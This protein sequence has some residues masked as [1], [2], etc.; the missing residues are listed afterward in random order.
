LGGELFT[1]LLGSRL[2]FG[3]VDLMLAEGVRCGLGEAGED[4]LLVTFVPESRFWSLGG[5]RL[6]PPNEGIDGSEVPEGM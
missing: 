4:L 6:L 1:L 3:G 2:S 5:P